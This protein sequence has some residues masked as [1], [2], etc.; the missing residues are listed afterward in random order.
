METEGP[1]APLR[2][3]LEP[4]IPFRRGGGP[5]E[6]SDCPRLPLMCP[7]AVPLPYPPA[8]R[9]GAHLQVAVTLEP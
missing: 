5:L 6:P 3:E 4:G 7:G 2:R 9:S 8:A 1:L